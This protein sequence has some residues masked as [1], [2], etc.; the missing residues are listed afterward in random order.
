[1]LTAVLIFNQICCDIKIFE[2]IV[3]ITVYET[4]VDL[5]YKWD[6]TKYNPYL[7]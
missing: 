6:L 7:V 4:H 5:G 2:C 3:D 1:M